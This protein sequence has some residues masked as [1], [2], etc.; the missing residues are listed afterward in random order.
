MALFPLGILSAAAGG[1]ETYELI[2]TTVLGGT[3][4]S[5]T[6]SSL[7]TY[8]ST[9]KH[10]QIRTVARVSA[11]QVSQVIGIQIN[12]DTG[13]K[14]S[15]P[16]VQGNCSTVSSFGYANSPTMDFQRLTA[17]NAT[18]NSFGALVIDIIDPYAAKNKTL[19]TL[20][21]FTSTGE[22]MV[23]LTSGAYLNTSSITSITCLSFSPSNFVAGSRFSLYGIRG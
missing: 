6:F 1:G 14:Y 4:T 19:R 20:G 5:V 9:Y 7:A 15:G 22:N 12:G 16:G 13:N 23:A 17:A 18:A 2:S 3:A 10:L 8:A 21:G 11:S